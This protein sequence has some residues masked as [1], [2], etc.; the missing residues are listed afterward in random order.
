MPEEDAPKTMTPEPY[1]I[2]RLDG[3]TWNAFADLVERHHGIYG[4][5][6]CAPHHAEYQ[7]GTSD[8]RPFKEA[9]VRTGRARAALVLDADGNAQGWCQYGR[10]ESL[11]LKHARAYAHDPPPE[12]R[13]R[14][15]C[16]FVDQ[17][18]R[19]RG[20]ARAALQGALAAIA[21]D[22]GGLVEAISETTA[23]RKAQ[24]RFLFSGTVELFEELG[25]TRVRPVGKY[26]WI[27][28][29]TLPAHGPS[30]A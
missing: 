1:T 11:R 29:H 9:L 16:L 30:G 3:T 13:W 15:A 14:I 18:H 4:G 5:C 28:S 17:R 21:A 24:G 2:T 7:R 20:I 10:S 23:G 25:F 27:V 12:A 19:G 26:A 6:W 22:G 8:P